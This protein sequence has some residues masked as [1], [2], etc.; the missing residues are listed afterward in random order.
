MTRHD[1][2][3]M[4][5]RPDET[6]DLTRLE[7]WLRAHLEGADGPLSIRQFG[8]GH[9]NLTYLLDFGGSEYVLRRPPLGPVAPSAHDM[10]R[11]HRVLSRLWQKFP[12][13]PRSFVL[14]QDKEILGVDFHVLERKE[15]FVIRNT[16]AGLLDGQPDLAGR[17]GAMIPDV[18]AD[19]HSVRPE[20]VGLDD[21]GRPEGFVARQVD[22]W[23]KRWYAAVDDGA[24]EVADVI[25]WIERDIPDSPQVSLIHND[26]KLDNLMV[27]TDDP[28]RAVAVLDWDMCTRGDPL[29]DFATLLSYWV[30]DDDPAEA[31]A[32]AR[33]PTYTPGF[34]SREEAITL[35]GEVSGR[36]L[37]DF[38]FHRVL[39]LFK[40]GVI[41]LQLYARYRRGITKDERFEPLGRTADATLGFTLDVIR[42]Q[43]V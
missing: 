21:L 29:F 35:Y 17:I 41:L 11:E 33:M 37:S 26:F 25:A 38:Q 2:E 22:G 18:L 39:C 24:P 14:C 3:T 28:S 23:M 10:T 12:L 30:Q 6:L 15:G 9:A 40:L 1:P 34:M 7:P 31:L 32:F 8:G 5:V 42:G 36:D 4:A 13:A 16:N 19:L 43:A 27:A 20:E